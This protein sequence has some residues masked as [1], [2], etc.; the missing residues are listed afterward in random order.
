MS[1][2][3]ENNKLKDRNQQQ[4][5]SGSKLTTPRTKDPTQTLKKGLSHNN[6]KEEEEP[7]RTQRRPTK[8]GLN[9]TLRRIR[10]LIVEGRSNSEI[11]DILQLEERTFYRYMAKIYEIDQAL[12][13]EQEK[14]TLITEF[15]IFKD[16]LLKSYRWL[17]AMADNENIK[18]ETRLKVQQYALEVAVSVL[19]LELEGP[20][21]I[22]K[23]GSVE[24]IFT[25]SKSTE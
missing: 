3:M 22:Q 9:D 21:V 6:T 7:R 18:A 10:H 23:K 1:S 4:S 8:V 16:R 12:F 19:K 2:M 11:Q 13:A 15:G 24:E 5:N 20:R 25:N 17:I 14:K